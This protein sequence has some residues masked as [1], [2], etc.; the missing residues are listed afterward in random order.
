MLAQDKLMRLK[1]DFISNITHELKTPIATVSVALEALSRFK[2]K[3]NPQA[4]EEYL[5]MARQELDRLTLLT[6]KVLTTSLFDEQGVKLKFESIDLSLLISNVLQSM[7]L[8]FKKHNSEIQ[9][10]KAGTDF[11]IQGHHFH[12]T[13]VIYNLFD[14]ALKYS[15]PGTKIHIG[16]H[17]VS[18]EIRIAVTDKGYGI[19]QEY[20]Q[21]QRVADPAPRLSCVSP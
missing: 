15:S 11:V 6:D 5:D 2:A 13:N 16:L 1:N 18:N 7:Q 21:T 8:L 17:E 12:L 3:D 14:N 9:F 10:D 4:T 19:P 20:Q